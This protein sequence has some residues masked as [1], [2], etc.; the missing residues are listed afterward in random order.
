MIIVWFILSNPSVIVSV[1]IAGGMNPLMIL[2]MLGYVAVLAAG[3]LIWFL[4]R[5]WVQGAVI[6]QSCKG[7]EVRKSFCVA[8]R[9]YFQL[10]GVTVVL[11]VV[12]GGLGFVPYIGWL[13]SIIA[14]LVFFFAFQS[15]IVGGSGLEKSLVESYNIFRGRALAVFLSLLTITLVAMAVSLIFTMPAIVLVWSAMAPYIS[16]MSA[17]TAAAVVV[18]VLLMNP[19]AFIASGAVLIAGGALSTSFSLKA[20]TELYMQLR[21][22]KRFGLV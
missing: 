9:R 19:L 22:K 18:F 21:K 14:T 17:A 12:C 13:L 8:R 15:V 4:L 20:Q 6:H 3:G 10:L 16:H 7:K 5:L 1:I 11:A 2:S